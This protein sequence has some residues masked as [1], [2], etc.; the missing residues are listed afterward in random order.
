[1]SGIR[2]RRRCWCWAVGERFVRVIDI[3]VDPV[4]ISVAVP[5]SVTRR[6]RSL[7]SLTR[8][9][10]CDASDVNDSRTWMLVAREHRRTNRECNCVCAS[11]AQVGAAAS[12]CRLSGCASSTIA[13]CAFL[14]SHSLLVTSDRALP[15]ILLVLTLMN[16]DT[17]ESPQLLLSYIYVLG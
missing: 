7:R 15:V 16:H 10:C 3:Y 13:V 12:S 6:P 8:H 2:N 14:S 17:H 4:S 5:V 11:Q 1:M 9:G